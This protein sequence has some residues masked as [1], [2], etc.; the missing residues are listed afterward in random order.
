MQHSSYNGFWKGQ[1]PNTGREIIVLYSRENITLFLI[2]LSCGTILLFLFYTHAYTHA[3]A[4]T[5]SLALWAIFQK[6][7][8]W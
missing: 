4:H 5:S 2:I 7:G 6:A 3:H 8:V 1:I